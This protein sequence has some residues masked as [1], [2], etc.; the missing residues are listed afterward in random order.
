MSHWPV[1]VDT[2]LRAAPKKSESIVSLTFWRSIK[3]L[4]RRLPPEDD[5]DDLYSAWLYAVE[6]AVPRFLKPFFKTSLE[7]SFSI[8]G[9]RG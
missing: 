2:H 8:T 9:R 6:K 1:T 5:S 4:K 3:S 7:P